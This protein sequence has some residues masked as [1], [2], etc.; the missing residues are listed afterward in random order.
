M[1]AEEN[2]RYFTVFHSVMEA[3]VLIF[4]ACHNF[5][6]YSEAVVLILMRTYHILFSHIVY[7]TYNVCIFIN[8]QYLPFACF[9][10]MCG[11]PCFM[12]FVISSLMFEKHLCCFVN[13]FFKF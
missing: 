2:I 6:N 1:A 3:V 7:V 5:V 12:V 9:T 8:S 4:K 11:L 13:C 10:R